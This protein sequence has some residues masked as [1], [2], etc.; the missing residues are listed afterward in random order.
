MFKSIKENEYVKK[1]IELWNNPRYRSILIL[2]LYIIFFAVIIASIKSK[3]SFSPIDTTKKDV[4]EVYQEMNNY[5]YNATIESESMQT[6]IGHVY[7]DRQII[8]FNG[9]NYYYNSVYLYKQEE[10][11]YTQI[12]GQLLEFEI[13]R[14]TPKL[15]GSLVENGTFESKTEYADGKVSNTYLVNASDFIELYFG[16][17]TETDDLITVTLLQDSKSI[18]KAELDLTTIY[19]Q[20]QISNQHDYMVVIEYSMIDEINPIIVNVES[21]E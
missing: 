18:I 14:I 5:K 1:I 3:Q 6:L 2:G 7:N 21:S 16:D 15:I 8:T 11:I 13:W 17:K 12:S 10:N 4:M 20:Q 9:N 19:H